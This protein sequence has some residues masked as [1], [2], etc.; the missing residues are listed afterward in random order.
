MDPTAKM[1]GGTMS[2]LVTNQYERN[3]LLEAALNDLRF[4]EKK[5]QR[6][7]FTGGQPSRSTKTAD[8]RIR[9]TKRVL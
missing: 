2:A 7:R 5:R 8:A 3:F 4:N 9:N 6:L 1:G